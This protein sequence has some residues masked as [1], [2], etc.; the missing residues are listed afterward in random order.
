[1][2]TIKTY[3]V[4]TAIGVVLIILVAMFVYLLPY[5]LNV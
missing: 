5:A 4:E 2:K 1:M 3:K